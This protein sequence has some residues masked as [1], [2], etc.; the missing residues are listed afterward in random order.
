MRSTIAC[1]VVLLVVCV[2]VAEIPHVISYQ[3]KVTD[4]SGTPVA[5]GSYTMRFR[6]YDGP[7]AGSLLWDSGDRSVTLSGGV[8]SVLL[9]ESP[10]PALT[11]DFDASY[12]LLVTFSGVDQAPRQ[13]LASTGSAYM[14]SGL[15]PGTLIQGAVASG[16]YSAIY[17]MNMATTGEASMGE[18]RRPPG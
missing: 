16:S 5:D 13:R 14:A 10:Q 15:V 2:A 6:I 12:W 17:A 4:I 8:F 11:L 1:A 18:P 7:S 9:G 3:G